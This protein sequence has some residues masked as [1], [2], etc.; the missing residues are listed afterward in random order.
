MKAIVFSE[1]GSPDLLS[2]QDVPQPVPGDNDVLVKVHASSINSWDLEFQSGTLVNRLMYGFLRPKPDKR[3]PGSDIAGTVER[4]GKKVTRFHPGDKVFGDLWDSWGGFAEF[5]CTPEWSL[6]TKPANLTFEQAAT[7][8]Q[9]GVLALQGLRAVGHIQTGQKVLINGA[10]GGVG[11]FAIQI[12]RLNGCEVTGVDAT[13]KLNSIRSL[14]AD[15]VIDYTRNDFT[16]NGVR[17]D[18]ILDC[19][20]TR[21]VSSIKR[22]LHPGGSYAFIGGSIARLYQVLAFDQWASRFSAQRYRLVYEG[23]NLG[24]SDLTVMIETGQLVPKI[25][26]VY[27]LSEVPEAMQYF[28]DGLHNG[29]IAI[30]IAGQMLT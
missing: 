15:H 23:P 16:E 21:S 3:V 25:D 13:H 6:E 18:L 30:A 24:L 7:V 9:A 5:A 28:N 17:Y 22:A 12:A 29:K 11:S 4:V 20:A 26:R 8:P 2:L 27:A 1:Y 14:G 19:Q 10:G